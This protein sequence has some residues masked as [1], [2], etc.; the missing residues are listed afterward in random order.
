VT[1]VSLPSV[2]VAITPQCAE[3]IRQIAGCVIV[4]GMAS[5]LSGRSAL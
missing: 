5:M 4:S 3:Q 2:T 1:F